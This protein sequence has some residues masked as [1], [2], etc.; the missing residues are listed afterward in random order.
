M[1][2]IISGN[3]M[4]GRRIRQPM[5]TDN[6]KETGE[7]LPGKVAAET[8][9]K[10]GTS[11]A[12]WGRCGSRCSSLCSRAVAARRGGSLRSAGC[13]PRGQRCVD[14]SPGR[15]LGSGVL[16][17]RSVGRGWRLAR[18]P[19][20]QPPPT[21]VFPSPGAAWR[22]LPLS[23]C[24]ASDRAVRAA[25]QRVFVHHRSTGQARCAHVRSPGRLSFLTSCESPRL[26]F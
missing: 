22:S 24:P 16:R 4:R 7:E 10:G 9:G 25:R 20:P 15:V 2:R 26:L 21:A 6:M 23:R 1:L 11:A 18:L 13:E 5:T 12:C 19:G 3:L 8:A 17:V 14:A